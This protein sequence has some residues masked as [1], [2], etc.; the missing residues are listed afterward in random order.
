MLQIVHVQRHQRLG[1]FQLQTPWLYAMLLH[2][3]QHIGRKAVL[4]ELRLTHV[5][6]QFQLRHHRVFLPLFQLQACLLQHPLPQ[7]RHQTIA[8]GMVDE[9]RRHEQAMLGMLPAQQY[10]CPC[11]MHALVQLGLKVQHKLMLAQRLL[12]LMV[13]I[14]MQLGIRVQH[15]QQQDEQ[16]HSCATIHPFAKHAQA[17]GQDQ[18]RKRCPWQYLQHQKKAQ[19]QHRQPHAEA[20]A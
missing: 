10:L 13:H 6:G 2:S 12:Q 11:H 15:M 4:P 8:L 5:H 7:R 20:C 16:Q 14:G 17:I 1:Q 3:T 9:H 19:A 18:F